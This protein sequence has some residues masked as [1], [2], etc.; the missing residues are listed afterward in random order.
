MVRFPALLPPAVGMK[1]TLAVQLAPA[2][3]LDP[4]ELVCEKSPLAVTPVMLRATLPV[5][6]ILTL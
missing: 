2:A 3:M 5:F 1:V 6:V 4:Q